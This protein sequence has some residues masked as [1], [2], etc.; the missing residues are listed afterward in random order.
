MR[1]IAYTVRCAFQDPS[2]AE[3]WS[4]WLLDTHVSDVLSAL[5]P[6]SRGLSYSRSV[7]AILSDR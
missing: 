2:I 5:F 3:E 4:R 7:G 6:L 1:M